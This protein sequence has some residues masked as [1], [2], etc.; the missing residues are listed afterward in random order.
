MIIH[1][2]TSDGELIISLIEDVFERNWKLFDEHVSTK[3]RYRLTSTYDLYTIFILV[4]TPVVNP[5]YFDRFDGFVLMR[6]YL[7]C[8]NQSIVTS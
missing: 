5:K 3:T 4:L 7:F 8:D 6:E 1:V 2:V